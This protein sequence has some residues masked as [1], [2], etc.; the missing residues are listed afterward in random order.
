M[1]YM[2][3]TNI[4]SYVLKNR[5][6]TVKAH[7][8]KVGADALCISTIVLAELYYGAA[9]HSKSLVIRGEIENFASRLSVMSW[10]EAAADHY[11]EIR[12]ALKKQGTPIGAMDM[13]IAAH[14]RSLK[15]TLVSHNTKH[16]EKIPALRIANWV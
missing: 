12:S 14:A 10:D 5:P 15:A 4:C 3:D 8:D 11:G 16:F 13:M 2:L 7:F 9:R 1:L 6:A